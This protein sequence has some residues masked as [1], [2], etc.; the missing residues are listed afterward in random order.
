MLKYLF[1]MRGIYE[2]FATKWVYSKSTNIIFLFVTFLLILS[3]VHTMILNTF[4][5]EIVNTFFLGS[6]YNPLRLHSTTVK[7]SDTDMEFSPS[8]ILNQ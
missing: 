1:V 8:H 4:F 7:A 3:L 2:G 6:V 5:H